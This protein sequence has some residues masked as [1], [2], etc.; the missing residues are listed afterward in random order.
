MSRV[1]ELRRV[2]DETEWERVVFAA[3]EVGVE[4]IWIVTLR[5]FA[6]SIVY[7]RLLDVF[8]ESDLLTPPPPAATTWP[9]DKLAIAPMSQ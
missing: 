4:R 8:V 5:R 1:G 6:V 9:S 3:S 2:C 7:P